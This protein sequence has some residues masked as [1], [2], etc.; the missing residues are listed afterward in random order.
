MNDFARDDELKTRGNRVGPWSLV[1]TS[2]LDQKRMCVCG[3]L[4]DV[5]FGPKA[6]IAK[7]YCITSSAG[8]TIAGGTASPS[9]LAVLR[10]IASSNFVG[11]STGRSMSALT[12]KADMCGAVADVCYGPRADIAPFTRSLR[13]PVQGLFYPR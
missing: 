3:A 13:L 2:V 11:N 10:L 5:R 1:K 9:A 8:A 6:D 4:A 7:A 12:P